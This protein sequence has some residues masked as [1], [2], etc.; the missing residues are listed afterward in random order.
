MGTAP[1]SK[2]MA[3]TTSR[4]AEPIVLDETNGNDHAYQGCL[5][6]PSNFRD[7]VLRPPPRLNAERHAEEVRLGIAPGIKAASGDHA[8]SQDLSIDGQ[9]GSALGIIVPRRES[10]RTPKC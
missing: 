4:R 2:P 8:E 10:I 3:G 6:W 7:E 1:C 9:P 5:F